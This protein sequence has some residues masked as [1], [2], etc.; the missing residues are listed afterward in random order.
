MRYGIWDFFG[1]TNDEESVHSIYQEFDV[2]T[3]CEKTRIC[4][5]LPVGRQKFV[6]G[7]G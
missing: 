2:K 1:N 5:N 4:T 7:A 6:W 3:K